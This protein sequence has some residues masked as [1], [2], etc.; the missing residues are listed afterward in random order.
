MRVLNYEASG[1]ERRSTF[2]F[3][4]HFANLSVAEGILA[5]QDSRKF[6]HTDGSFSKPFLSTPNILG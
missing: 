5:L 4:F 1:R 6:N 2:G 3:S